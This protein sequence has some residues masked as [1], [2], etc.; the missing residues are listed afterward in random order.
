MGE[1]DKSPLPV[2]RDVTSKFHHQ[3]FSYC[4][5]HHGGELPSGHGPGHLGTKASSWEAITARVLD[6][7]QAAGGPTARTS[8]N[9]REG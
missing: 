1:L 2:S 3:L 9:G 7:P 5:G 6:P 8:P 4:N